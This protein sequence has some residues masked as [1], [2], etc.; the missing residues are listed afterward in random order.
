VASPRAA[1]TGQLW[2]GLLAGPVAWAVQLQAVYALAAWAGD[3][4]SLLPL[5][6]VSL[7]CLLGA[8]A[9]WRLAWRSWRAVGGWPSGGDEVAAGRTRLMS[10]LGLMTGTL[11]SL[12]IVAHWVA[13]AMLPPHP[14]RTT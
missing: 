14:G 7:V 5:H 13:V 12:L 9:G 11:F 3:G 8:V 6:L 2:V 4:G 10:V 1:D